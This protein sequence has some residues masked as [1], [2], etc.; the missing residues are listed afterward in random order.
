[1]QVKEYQQFD[2]VGLSAL[3]ARGEVSAQAVLTAAMEAIA[4]YNPALNA[5]T[6][7]FEYPIRAE[8]SSNHPLPFAGVPFL[9][10]DLG[11]PLAGTSM[12]CGAKFLKHF[13]WDHDASLVRRYKRAGLVLLGKTNT[14]EFGLSATTESTY[15]GASKNPWHQDY[16]SGGSSGGSAA[17]VASGMVPMAHGND[18]GG[19]IRIP[20]SCCGLLGLK[21]SR[22]RMPTGPDFGRLWQGM[23]V[24]HAITRSVRDSAALLDCTHGPDLGAPL[25]APR[26]PK[27]Y[28][29]IIQT[30]P[31]PLKIALVT[32]A[33]L[34][35]KT[36]PECVKAAEH[37]AKLCESLGHEIIPTRLKIDAEKTKDAFMTIVAV[38]CA[39]AINH[40]EILTGKRARHGDLEPATWVTRRQGEHIKAKAFLRATQYIERLARDIATWMQ[41]FDM[42][43][44]PTLAM[45]PAKLGQLTP[46]GLENNILSILAATRFHFLIDKAFTK[47][48][49]DLFAYMPYTPLFN[50]TGQPAMSVPLY[51]N[52]EGLPIG[53]QFAA[54]FG[55]E[56]SLLQLAAQLEQAQPWEPK[57]L[58]L[59]NK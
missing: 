55:D 18:G 10:K 52:P 31:K 58:S 51:W 1:M 39:T 36:H 38:E 54:P 33:Y 8:E 49:N 37:A 20:A 17:A 44:S 57:L 12:T 24:D 30:P 23:V 28:G 5:I 40:Y 35:A 14:P 46:S 22:G 15:L 2:A 27:P 13:K 21:P 29:E 9:L 43:L 11:A 56:A 42:I 19:S 7:L 25:Y 47:A 16:S 32:Q 53:V 3:I 34:T 50:M 48:A 6:D 59:L 41:P 45:P 26:P 4:N